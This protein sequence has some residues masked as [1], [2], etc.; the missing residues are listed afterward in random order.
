MPEYRGLD[1]ITSPAFL[2]HVTGRDHPEA[3]ERMTA[4]LEVLD[5]GPLSGS[6]RRVAPRSAEREFVAAVHDEAYLLRFEEACLSGREYFLHTDNR[7]CF[8]TYGISLL[9]AGA[10]LTGIDLIEG[11]G[12]ALPFCCIRPPGHHAEAGL[13]LGFCFLNNVAIAARYWQS[14]YG[15]RRIFIL[16][17]DAHH[18]NG[19][20]EVFDEDPEVFYASI[21][22]HPTFSFPGTGYADEDGNGAGRGTTL[23]IPLPPGAG[24]RE[25]LNVLSNTVEPAIEAF[26][27]EALIVAA[28]FDGH[29]MDD[30]SG[31]SYTTRLYGYIGTYVS[32]WADR[33]CGG[34]VLGILEGGYHLGALASSVEAYLAGL[35]MKV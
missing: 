26:A 28:G 6:V 24:E 18:G 12:P 13:A 10:C 23:N 35:S 32:A 17:W 21:H 11:R 5:R 8:D 1:L 20:Q 30:M 29:V 3:P 19:I 9:A 33:Y 2:E 34:K 27:P 14:R 4:I 22:E 25:V 7:I 16:D 31:L 15:R